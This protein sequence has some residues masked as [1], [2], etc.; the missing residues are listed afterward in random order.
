MKNQIKDSI[1]IFISEYQKN[2]W[3][4]H[5]KL[6]DPIALITLNDLRYHLG[7]ESISYKEFKDYIDNDEYLSAE[8]QQFLTNNFIHYSSSVKLKELLSDYK[9]SII[10]LDKNEFDF[11]FSNIQSFVSTQMKAKY[12]ISLNCDNPKEDVDQED[13]ERI[14]KTVETY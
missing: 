10:K 9:D 6:T 1:L 11:D 8:V 3:L 12:A 5:N 13:A 2:L 4:D 7:F 14:L